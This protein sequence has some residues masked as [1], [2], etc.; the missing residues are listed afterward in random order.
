MASKSVATL[1]LATVRCGGANK[2]VF[3]LSLLQIE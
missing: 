3:E 2:I 1:A